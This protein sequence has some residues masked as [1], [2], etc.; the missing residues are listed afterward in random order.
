M[1]QQLVKAN[2]HIL[3]SKTCSQLIVIYATKSKNILN[4]PT[5]N[6]HF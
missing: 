4:Q 1:R 5:L 3:I 2:A 6:D